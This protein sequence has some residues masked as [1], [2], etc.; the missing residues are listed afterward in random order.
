LEALVRNDAQLRL[1]RVDIKSW[2]SAV[3]RQY[4]IR[5]IPHLRL[6]QNGIL[7]AEGT[8]TVLHRFSSAVP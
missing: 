8:R 6:Y 1:R 4:N 5:S 7:I 3:A 2:D